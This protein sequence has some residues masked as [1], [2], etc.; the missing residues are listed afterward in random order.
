MSRLEQENLGVY[1]GDL[2]PDQDLVKLALVEVF[3]RVKVTTRKGVSIHTSVDVVPAFTA[4]SVRSMCESHLV[5]S[6]PSGWESTGFFNFLEEVSAHR[7]SVRTAGRW[8]L[9]VEERLQRGH[10][11]RHAR[12]V[13]EVDFGPLPINSIGPNFFQ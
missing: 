4:E 5:H 8:H 2:R 11:P 12:V 10:R 7:H 6:D 1:L 3:V 13:V 9:P